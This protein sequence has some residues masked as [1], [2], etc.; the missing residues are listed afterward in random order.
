MCW[1]VIHALRACADLGCWRQGVAWQQSPVRCLLPCI[2][3]VARKRRFSTLSLRSA[4]ENGSISICTTVFDLYL[5][6][7]TDEAPRAKVCHTT[8]VSDL[9]LYPDTDE[10]PRAKVCH[11]T[12]VFDLLLYSIES[13]QNDQ[14]MMAGDDQKMFSKLTL[15][16]FHPYPDLMV[17]RCVC[18]SVYIPCNKC[19]TVRINDAD[20]SFNTVGERELNRAACRRGT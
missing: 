6:P 14:W 16:W 9:Y 12:T 2:R 20:I 8:T 13:Y 10:A 1:R 11:K 4:V 5:Y 19:Q 7:D 15:I 3:A 18:D 17:S